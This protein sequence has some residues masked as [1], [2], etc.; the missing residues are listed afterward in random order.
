MTAA[1]VEVG[2]IGPGYFGLVAGLDV[3]SLDLLVPKHLAPHLT[4]LGLIQMQGNIPRLPIF[5]SEPV[6]DEPV[7]PNTEYGRFVENW[8][9]ALRDSEFIDYVRSKLPADLNRFPGYNQ[10]AVV[11]DNHPG[12]F[13]PFLYDAVAGLVQSF[14]RAG[15]KSTFPQGEEVYDEFRQMDFNGTSG[16]VLIDPA[17]GTRAYETIQFIMW[18]IRALEDEDETSEVGRVGMYPT[19]SY[20]NGYWVEIPGQ[21][22]VFNGGASVPPDSLPPRAKD[23]NYIGTPAR[24]IGLSLMAITFISAIL[25]VAWLLLNL[26]EHVVESAQPIFLL[27]VSLG[28]V[29]MASSILP[30]SVEE[31]IVPDIAG[32]DIACMAGP[33]LYIAGVSVVLS[34]IFAK[35]AGLYQV[36]VAF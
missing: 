35:T 30:L 13:R 33:W 18:N 16:R 8:Q 6:P 14:C 1:G 4:G 15:E 24:A 26:R 3:Y 5:P 22:F 28:S 36:R 21:S 2:I 17:T 34:P 32:L 19:H 20:E 27:L 23:F 12:S 31:T 7:D 10:S 9:T 29:V 25:S 11:F